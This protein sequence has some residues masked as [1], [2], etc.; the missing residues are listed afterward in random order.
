MKKILNISRIWLTQHT[1][2][3]D[4]IG[5]KKAILKVKVA[6]SHTKGEIWKGGR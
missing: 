2:A 1:M 3:H 6:E 5:E 4:M